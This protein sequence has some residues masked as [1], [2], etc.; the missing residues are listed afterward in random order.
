MF[1]TSYLLT[2]QLMY[3]SEKDKKKVEGPCKNVYA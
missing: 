1:Y 3:R 2:K